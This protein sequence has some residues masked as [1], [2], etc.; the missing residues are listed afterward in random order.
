[1]SLCCIPWTMKCNG[2]AGN[3]VNSIRCPYHKLVFIRRVCWRAALRLDALLSQQTAKFVIGRLLRQRTQKGLHSVWACL[4]CLV[5][6]SIQWLI[7]T[8]KPK[9]I[10][11]RLNSEHKAGSLRRM[12][13]LIVVDHYTYRN[14][15]SSMSFFLT[16]STRTTISQSGDCSDT[17]M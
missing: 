2:H 3:M 4:I 1:M 14:S 5:I 17:R 10:H 16:R 11:L 6:R 15:S 13:L 9:R 8:I 7:I 12:P